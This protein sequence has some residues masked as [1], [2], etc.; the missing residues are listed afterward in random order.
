MQKGKITYY[1]KKYSSDE[2]VAGV[3]VD[4]EYKKKR[5]EAKYFCEIDEHMMDSVMWKKSKIS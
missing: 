2:N 1:I 4:D 3:V 5:H